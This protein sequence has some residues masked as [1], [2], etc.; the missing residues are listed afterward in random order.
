MISFLNELYIL[1]SK[2]E[3]RK[4]CF[5]N[6]EQRNLIESFENNN[7]V[8]DIVRV[9]CVN[10]NSVR[11]IIWCFRKTGQ[12]NSRNTRNRRPNLLCSVEEKPVIGRVDE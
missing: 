12:V 3:K 9:M 8:D 10:M 11:T 6:D 5:S 7:T 1:V 2:C 4:K